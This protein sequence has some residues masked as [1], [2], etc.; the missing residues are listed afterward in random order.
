MSSVA[1]RR[2]VLRPT[3]QMHVYLARRSRSS[4]KVIPHRDANTWRID[5][6]SETVCVVNDVPLQKPSPRAR[7]FKWVSHA[8]SCTV[9]IKK[10]RE[11]LVA[12]WLLDSPNLFAQVSV[13]D[14]RNLCEDPTGRPGGC[15][16]LGA[17]Q[18]CG[19]V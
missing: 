7:K 14:N 12:N 17:E 11:L 15:I 2:L 10:L 19:R 5:S 18:D 4:T 8:R 13:E 6:M 1:T 9:S 16:V 3:C